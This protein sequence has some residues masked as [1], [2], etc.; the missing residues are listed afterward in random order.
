MYAVPINNEESEKYFVGLTNKNVPN[1]MFHICEWD[2][3]CSRTLFIWVLFSH[4]YL[5][6]K[7]QW[8]LKD[9]I[10][11][12]VVWQLKVTESQEVT[13]L[14]YFFI[15]LSYCRISVMSSILEIASH[16]DVIQIW[17]LLLVLQLTACW[18][19]VKSYWGNSTNQILI[20]PYVK[21]MKMLKGHT[22]S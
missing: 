10:V 2:S 21:Y 3:E 19:H 8:S 14:R 7:N 15:S 4:G 18:I 13:Q 1:K 22:N 5:G 20:Y 9:N 11:S 17:I 16:F 6:K 12:I